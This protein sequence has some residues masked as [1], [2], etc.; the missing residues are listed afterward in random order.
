MIEFRQA[1]SRTIAKLILM[2]MKREPAVPDVS[3][4]LIGASMKRGTLENDRNFLE[5]DTLVLLIV[6]RYTENH[7]LSLILS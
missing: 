2:I 5:G 4:Y 3:S 6:G 1:S 7:I